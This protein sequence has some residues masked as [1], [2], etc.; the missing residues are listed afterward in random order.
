MLFP[1]WYHGLKYLTGNELRLGETLYSSEYL[2]S[3]NG[4]YF[5]QLQNDGDLVLYGNY[6]GEA[7]QVWSSGT[8]G[9][10]VQ[11]YRLETTE[12]GGNLV[13]LDSAGNTIWTTGWQFNRFFSPPKS[14]P[15]SSPNASLV[16]RMR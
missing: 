6:D 4:T 13:I 15:K 9:G 12:E 10:S 2:Q 14:W 7:T 1:A 16:L 8:G 3:A 11:M 5:L